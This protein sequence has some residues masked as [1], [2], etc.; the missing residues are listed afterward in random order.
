M[1][2]HAED[3]QLM[4]S[5]ARGD[6]RAFTDVM[7]RHEDMVFAVCMRLM[8]NRDRA[9]DATQDTF[10][11]VLRKADRFRGESALSTWLYR[12]ATNTC[13]DLQRKAKR[14]SAESL[15]EHH[16]PDD[17]SAQDPFDAAELRPDIAAALTRIP[18]EYRAA[19]VLADAHGLALSDVAE[20]LEVPVG[21]VK[22]RIYRARRLLA[23][24]L[25]N[26]SPPSS[27]PRTEDA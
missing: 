21:T 13:F 5:V 17:H 22:S 4:R 2:A 8:G 3:L 1:S 19:V 16:D 27:R 6:R 10:V 18:D 15:P 14:R 12:V 25:G 9:L 20:I 26:L 11:T 23:R 24:E 7:E